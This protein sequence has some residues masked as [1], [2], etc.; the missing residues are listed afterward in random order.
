MN[1]TIPTYKEATEE[2]VDCLVNISMAAYGVNSWTILKIDGKD[3][4]DEEGIWE[5][6]GVEPLTLDDVNAVAMMEL[7]GEK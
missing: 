7:R 5:Q 6:H 3:V 1:I 2:Y 4:V